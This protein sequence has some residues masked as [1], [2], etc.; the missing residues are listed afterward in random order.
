MLL[1]RCCCNAVLLITVELLEAA[2]E[3]HGHIWENNID[4]E[5][6][7]IDSGKLKFV[8]D[9]KRKPSQAFCLKMTIVTCQWSR[10]ASL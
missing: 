7:Q 6:N 8:C 5:I 4:S 9:N 2:I 3:R 1:C 10:D